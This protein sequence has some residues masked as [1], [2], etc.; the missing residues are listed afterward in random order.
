MELLIWFVHE[1]DDVREDDNRHELSFTA[2]LLQVRNTFKP[3]CNKQMYIL[4]DQSKL[5]DKI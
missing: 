1:Y 2:P 5:N 4:I 3:D